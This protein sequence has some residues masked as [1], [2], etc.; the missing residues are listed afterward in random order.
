MLLH[1][2]M[3]DR[4]LRIMFIR[5]WYSIALGGRSSTEQQCRVG[6]GCLAAA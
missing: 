1:R 2:R 5:L 4:G 6:L 3:N